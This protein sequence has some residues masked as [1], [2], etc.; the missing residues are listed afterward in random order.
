MSTGRTVT[1]MAAL[2]QD[3]PVTP[4]QFE[5]REVRPTDVVIDVLYCG[6]CHSDLH[7]M[8][9]WG[10]HFPMVPGHEFVGRVREV[11]S[12]ATKHQVGDTVAVSVVV[13]SCGECPPCLAGLETYCLRGAIQTYG[14]VDP[15]DGSVT[16]GGWAEQVVVPEQF[17][18]AAPAGLDLAGAAP[19][20]CAGITTFAPLRHWNVGAGSR[21]GVVG[22][23]GL[24]HLGIRFAKAMGAEVIGFTTSES[25]RDDILGLGA[26]EVVVSR[27]DAQ[28][29]AQANRLDLVLDTVAVDHPVEPLL[30]TLRLDGTLVVLGLPPAPLQASAMTLTLGRRS[31]AGSG[32][33]GSVE[34]ADMLQF[35]ADHDIRAE[36]ELV[37][38]D[39]IPA[40]VE[41]LRNNDVRFRFV[42][43]RSSDLV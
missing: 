40:A 24:G 37:R 29:A 33:G 32:A 10:E 13:G 6:I 12:A 2:E 35:S 34:V 18:Y 3:G 16:R 4:W 21:V 23:G 17:V 27:D 36:V 38:P 9:P 22:I 41:R 31:L 19:L 8:G 15:V 30:Q 20:M 42:I 7:M 39:E 14:S 11:G 43:D 1:T 26:D 5:R 28:M 25:K